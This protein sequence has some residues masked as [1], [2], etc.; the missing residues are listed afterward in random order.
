MESGCYI[1]G[2]EVDAFERDWA[3]YCGVR[4][5]IGVGNGLEALHLTLRAFEIGAG[6]EV[7]VPSNTYVA[8]WL[9]VSCCGATPVPVEPDESTYTID[10]TRIEAAVTPNTRAIIPVHLYGLP[11]DM[12]PVMD[13]AERYGLRVIED[14]A[15]AHG[16]TYKGRRCGSLAHAACFS[17]YPGKNLG[18][19][20]D[21]GAVVTDC[22]ET[23]DRVRV[24]RNYGS[25]T[26]YLNETKGWNSRLDPLQAAF[27]RVKLEH[28]E[29]WNARRKKRAHQYLVELARVNGLQ[30]PAVPD[31]SD[32]AWHLFVVRHHRRDE[33]T[34]ALRAEGVETLIHYPVPPHLS[35]AYAEMT[36]T[37]NSLVRAERLADSVMSLPLGPHLAHSQ[38]RAVTRAMKKAVHSAEARPGMDFS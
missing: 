15:Q 13:V 17:F 21:A 4:H 26:K 25:R 7:I 12:D 22:G 31:S 29:E 18:A 37:P 9:A 35:G 24:L 14:A 10:P 5:C 30:L 36:R 3:A 8:T 19:M 38:L 34:A 23:A 6:D 2:E 1:L 20:G 16:A 33:L 27:L 28:L 32:P 11:V